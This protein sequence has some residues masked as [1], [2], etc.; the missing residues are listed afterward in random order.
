VHLVVEVVTMMGFGYG[1]L[2]MLAMVI[3]WV[4]LVAAAIWFVTRLFPQISGQPPVGDDRS[5]DLP[6]RSPEEILRER[7]ARGEISKEQ[8]EEMR[9]TLAS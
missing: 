1:G 2:G 7:Y 6:P 4:M 5:R 8:F 3:F 9:R